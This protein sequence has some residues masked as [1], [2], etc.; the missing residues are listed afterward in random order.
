[1]MTKSVPHACLLRIQAWHP[2]SAFPL[3]SSPYGFAAT[4][5]DGRGSYVGASLEGATQ[6]PATGLTES[7]AAAAE[8]VLLELDALELTDL[9]PLAV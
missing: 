4:S 9:D 2:A 1:M 5:P 3:P 6:T 7:G 8:S